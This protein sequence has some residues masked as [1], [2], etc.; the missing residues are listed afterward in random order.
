MIVGE[1]LRH[2]A[3][4]HTIHA[5]STGR[6]GSEFSGTYFDGLLVSFHYA[7]CRCRTCETPRP[8][9]RGARWPWGWPHEMSTALRTPET[10]ARA[11]ISGARGYCIVFQHR[12]QAMVG[13][14]LTPEDRTQDTSQQC[15][16]EP[17][18]QTNTLRG[19]PRVTHGRSSQSKNQVVIV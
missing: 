15:G 5:R 2:T 12:K 4:T 19:P 11:R 1:E 3:V 18:T 13:V 6:G 16:S 17:I 8:H 10:A 14:R 7:R 9:V